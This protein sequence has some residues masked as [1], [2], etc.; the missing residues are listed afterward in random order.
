[1]EKFKK[2]DKLICVDKSGYWALTL[3][4]VYYADKDSEDAT[5]PPDTYTL[6]L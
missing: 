5:F 3:G 6:L 4:K 2:G 1:M